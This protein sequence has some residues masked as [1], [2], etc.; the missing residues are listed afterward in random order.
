MEYRSDININKISLSF[1]DKKIEKE[2]QQYYF[3]DSLIVLRIALIIIALIYGAFGFLDITVAAQHK[4]LFFQ[5]RYLVVIP[6]LFLIFLLSF[7]KNFEKIWQFLL[8][9]AFLVGGTGIILM[10]IKMP[11][12]LTYY[13]GLMLV[14]SAGYFFVKLRFILATLAGWVTL[15][16]FL[17]AAILFSKLPAELLIAYLFFYISANIISMFAAYY[18]E[19]FNRKNFFLSIQLSQKK[20]ELEELNKNLESQV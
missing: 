14:F 17:F 15:F 9:V 1:K 10:I 16:I 8:F 5:I 2:Y 20:N 11:D 13:A 7:F 12:N 6:Y 19:L 4:S 18:I 3:K